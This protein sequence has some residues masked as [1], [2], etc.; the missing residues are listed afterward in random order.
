MISATI[1]G[2]ALAGFKSDADKV[3]DWYDNHQGAV[4][5]AAT[6]AATIGKIL[7]YENQLDFKSDMDKAGD[8]YKDH[9]GAVDGAATTAATIGKILAA[10]NDNEFGVKQRAEFVA[11][12]GKTIARIAS[13]FGDANDNQLDFKSDMDKAGDWYKD[14]QGAV[15][16]AATTAATIGKILALANEFDLK[17]DA[18]KVGDFYNNHYGAI[19]GAATVAAKIGKILAD[20][21]DNEFGVKQRAEFVAK[22]AGTIARVAG[23]FGDAND[24]ELDF[25][26]DMDKAGDWYK[27]HQGAVDGAATTAA[28]IGKILAVENDDVNEHLRHDNTLKSL[29]GLGAS[30][31]RGFLSF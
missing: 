21:N 19:D 27:D 13:M 6:T 29:K 31:K 20:E 3:G 15:D 4:D 24:N 23:M 16:G 14:H 22:H 11:K 12:H 18:D 10:A 7:A 28:T 17:S 2:V 8:W 9:Q 30:S 25:K 5:G 26:S 1:V